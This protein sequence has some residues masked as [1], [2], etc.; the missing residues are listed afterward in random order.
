MKAV[1]ILAVLAMVCLAIPASADVRALYTMTQ[2]DGDLQMIDSSGY[3]N[4]LWVGPEGA[5]G[6]PNG[7]LCWDD[8]GVFTAFEV[9]WTI[10]GKDLDLEDPLNESLY[11]GM[12]NDLI[13]EADIN[14]QYGGNQACIVAH[15]YSAD[16]GLFTQTQGS[17]YVLNYSSF[18]G[19]A[20]PD[21][22]YGWFNIYDTTLLDRNTWYHIKLEIDRN[23][24]GSIGDNTS[25]DKV[26]FFVTDMV[27][28]TSTF[29]IGNNGGGGAAA[30]RLDVMGFPFN[31]GK[32]NQGKLDNLM[33]DITPIPEP[34]MLILGLLALLKLRRK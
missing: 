24:S 27:N 14:L 16:Y 21:N 8:P 30:G 4:H 34:S 1:T 25:I 22:P 31:Y 9:G 12:E 18:G 3:G 28:P 33:I 19:I 17:Q 29:L 7:D 23:F 32:F 10:A 20:G 26:S 5:G 13:I 15:N 6:A 2:N 11:S